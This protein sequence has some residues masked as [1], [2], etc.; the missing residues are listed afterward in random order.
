MH[1]GEVPTDVSLVRRLLA[2]QFPA[3]AALSIEPVASA[4]TDNAIYRLGDELSVRLPRIGWADGQVAKEREWLP[5][6]APHLPVAVP[7]V[8]AVGRPTAEY[9][10]DWG[11]YR[12]LP[13][14]PPTSPDPALAADLAG[15]VR[16]LR[17]VD[18]VG[19]PV[20]GRGK[21][22]S[23][24]DVG[25]RGILADWRQEHDA[26]RL[27]ELW[28]SCVDAPAWT[29]PPTWSHGDL[30]PGNLL[31]RE[32]RLSA[33]IDFSPAGVGDPACDLIPAWAFFDGP[34]RA[35]YREALDVDDAMWRRGQG[36]ALA[37]AVTALPYYVVTNPVL[38]GIARTTLG[39][40]LA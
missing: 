35:A 30:L 4:G 14:S 39:N 15:F 3:W 31:V 13:G 19:A 27:L 36:W 8:V 29:G 18:P 40:L 7:E 12:W 11:V 22:L 5:I 21:P 38:A 6:L 16:A 17:A 34:A 2:G 24:R 32:G 26:A 37:F 20:A 25:V 9:A 33:V 10:W 1:D 28:T 23:T